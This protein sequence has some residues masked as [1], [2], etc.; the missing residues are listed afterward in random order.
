M[1]KL[2]LVAACAVLLA[3]QIPE[4]A[5]A[6]KKTSPKSKKAAQNSGLLVAADFEKEGYVSGYFSNNPNDNSQ[7]CSIEVVSPG[8]GD[9]GK[10]LKLVYDVDSPK[11]AYN[12]F[13]MK[14]NGE[15]TLDISKYSKLVF[16]V[17]GDDK[18]GYTQKIKL[19][20]K[21]ASEV[22]A[23]YIDGIRNDWKALEI[24][25]EYFKEITNWTQMTEF[26]ICFDIQT[27]KRTGAIYVDDITF[28]K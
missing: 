5:A 23:V 9:T 16:R 22:S 21:N 8:Y 28:V 3:G 11:E 25:L 18:L 10:C 24:P 12:G 20:L 1:H 6:A 7:S 4:A 14:L 2:V 17:K 27:T 26:V 15:S 19:E 13:W